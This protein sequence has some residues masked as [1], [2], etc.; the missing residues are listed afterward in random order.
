MDGN[1]GERAP[2][3]AEVAWS[4]QLAYDADLVM[5][6]HRNAESNLFEVVSRKVRRGHPFAFYLQ[7]DL[8]SGKR[9]ELFDV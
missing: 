9:E 5:A 6:V 2:A 3:L 8:D 4:K 1:Q 7:W